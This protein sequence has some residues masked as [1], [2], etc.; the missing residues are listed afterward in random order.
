MNNA[1]GMCML[2][3]KENLL[4]YRRYL[5]VLRPCVSLGECLEYVDRLHLRERRVEEEQVVGALEEV[6]KSIDVRMI[7]TDEVF[8]YFH[9][10]ALFLAVELLAA[11]NSKNEVLSLALG[12][13]L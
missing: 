11:Y 10:G 2:Q 6:L 1:L 12:N 5:S 13:R 4:H 3:G 7:D 9:V 8:N